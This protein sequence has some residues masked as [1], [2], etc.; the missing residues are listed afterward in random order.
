MT[1]TTKQTQSQPNDSEMLHVNAEQL[2]FQNDA[3]AVLSTGT[4]HDEEDL[5]AL[6]I[7]LYYN[8]LSAIDSIVDFNDY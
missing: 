5:Q 8:D 1:S 6:P 4:E 2:I 3:E 7:N